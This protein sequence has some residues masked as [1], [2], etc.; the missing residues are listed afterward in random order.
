MDYLQ[1]FAAIKSM[2]VDYR[3]AAA[4]GDRMYPAIYEQDNCCQVGFSD[5]QGN[6]IVIVEVLW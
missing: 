5:K 2:R 6:P 4:L 3:K 1:D